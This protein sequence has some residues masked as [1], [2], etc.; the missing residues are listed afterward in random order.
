MMKFS[1][2]GHVGEGVKW[3]GGVHDGITDG[4]KV[5]RRVLKLI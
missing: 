3:R 2:M 4:E 5:D 1:T